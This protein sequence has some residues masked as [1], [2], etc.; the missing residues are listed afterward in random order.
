MHYRKVIIVCLLIILLVCCI[1]FGL[2]KT[3]VTNFIKDPFYKETIINTDAATMNDPTV[4]NKN[5]IKTTP[6]VDAS[7]NTDQIPVSNTVS[8][9][10]T[11]LTQVQKMVNVSVAITGS[12]TNGIC[13]YTFTKDGAKP[14]VKS[15]SITNN[16]CAVSI[17]ELEFEMI[18]LWNLEVKYFSDNTQTTTN[19][20]IN[21]K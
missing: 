14:V 19:S 6:G 18:G 11:S 10:I 17:S 15:T 1:V 7:K 12:K 5:D 2:E 13:S 9:K 8:I 21:I 16:N 20:E 4:N 3:R